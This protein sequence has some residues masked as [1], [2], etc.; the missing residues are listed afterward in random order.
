MEWE[1]EMRRKERQYEDGKGR[2]RGGGKDVK[3]HVVLHPLR[4]HREVSPFVI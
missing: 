4:L 2:G 3:G 1:K